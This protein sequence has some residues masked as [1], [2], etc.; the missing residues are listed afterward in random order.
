M[1]QQASIGEKATSLWSGQ[2]DR[3]IESVNLYQKQCETLANLWS[4]QVAEVQKE[5]QRFMKEWMDTVTKSQADLLKQCQRNAKDA[6]S[7]FS[8]EPSR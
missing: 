3:W 8:E 6:V 2:V 5:G 1:A 4:N 7:F